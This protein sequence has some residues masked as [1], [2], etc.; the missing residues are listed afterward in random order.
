VTTSKHALT[1]TAVCQLV[2]TELRLSGT[3]LAVWNM[4]VQTSIGRW[5][6]LLPLPQDHK[7]AVGILRQLCHLVTDMNSQLSKQRPYHHHHQHYHHHLFTFHRSL[8]GNNMPL[9]VEI[10]IL[11]IKK[12]AK[13]QL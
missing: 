10:V 2:K 11:I 12:I 13:L 4:T 5:Q 8:F 3:T 1:E 7:S 9:D 6:R